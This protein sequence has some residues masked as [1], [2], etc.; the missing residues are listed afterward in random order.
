VLSHARQHGAWPGSGG[1]VGPR[2]DAGPVGQPPPGLLQAAPAV[3]AAVPLLCAQDL[4]RRLRDRRHRRRVGGGRHRPR[5]PHHRLDLRV[6]DRPAL[7]HH[8]G[9]FVPGPRLLPGRRAAREARGPLEARNAASV[10]PAPLVLLADQVLTLDAAA[11]IYAPG[12]VTIEGAEIRGVGPPPARRAG[13]VV[14]LR[15]SVLLPGLVNTHTHTPMWVFRGLIE[16][17]P[18]GQWLSGRMPPLERRLGPDD[19]RAGALAGCL[20]LLQN[21]V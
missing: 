14:D 4:G 16:D 19:L 8:R 21:G 18:R 3:V 2:A 1:A 17:V 7:R 20:E 11:T 10:S 6:P 13:E 9:G 15:G 12:A 5:L